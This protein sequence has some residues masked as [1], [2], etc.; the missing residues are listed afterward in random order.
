M[1][2]LQPLD[3][4]ERSELVAYLDG[5]L[6]EKASLAMEAKLNRDPRIRAEADALRR[7]WNLLDF[8]PKPEPSSNFTQRTVAS[9]AQPALRA[10]RW[11]P[12]LLGLG[13]AAA[14]IVAGMIGYASVPA[15]R[16]APVTEPKADDTEQ[17]VRD[18][19]V[20]DQV[21]QYQNAGDISFLHE[22]DRPELFGDDPTGH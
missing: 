20:I 12:W 13:W 4:D 14:V 2:E 8:L 9:I 7:A 6:D 5:E 3:D 18:L 11:R 16:V 22:L 10:R 15:G 1:P 17:L 19:R 21:R